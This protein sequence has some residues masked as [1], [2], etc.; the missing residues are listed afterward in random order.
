MPV[1]GKSPSGLDERPNLLSCGLGVCIQDDIAD[2]DDSDLL[3][4]LDC[5]LGSKMLS[6]LVE[7]DL[8]DSSLTSAQQRHFRGTLT[9]DPSAACKPSK[10][11]NHSF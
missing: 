5:R 6:K 3:E 4:V 2:D 1:S 7:W 9:P 8:G 11:S 10:V